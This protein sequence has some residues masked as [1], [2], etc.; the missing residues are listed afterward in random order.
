MPSNNKASIN[1]TKYTTISSNGNA[2]VPWGSL[3]EEIFDPTPEKRETVTYLPS[4]YIS[5]YYI[6]TFEQFLKQIIENRV[7]EINCKKTDTVEDLF[8]K[9]NRRIAKCK[10]FREGGEELAEKLVNNYVVV[11]AYNQKVEERDEVTC[12]EDEET[13][14]YLDNIVYRNREFPERLNLGYIYRIV[15]DIRDKSYFH[16]YFKPVIHTDTNGQNANLLEEEIM[17]VSFE[18]LSTTF[19]TITKD[20]YERKVKELF[21]KDIEKS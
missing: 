8:K 5:D 11:S 18:Q 3:D 6:D 17:V 15:L 7:N 14:P 1:K 19:K 20:E 13:V 2:G 21:I 12:C 16:V 10:K 9:L 4:T